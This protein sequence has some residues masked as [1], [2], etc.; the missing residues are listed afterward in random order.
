[1]EGYPTAM[2]RYLHSIHR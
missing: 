2:N 1:M